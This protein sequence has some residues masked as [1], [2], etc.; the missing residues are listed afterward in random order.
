[1]P[2][3]AQTQ[4]ETTEKLVRRFR[5]LYAGVTI[6]MCLGLLSTLLNGSSLLPTLGP[7]L[8]SASIYVGLR[9]RRD[10][11]VPLAL[12]ISAAVSLSLCLAIVHPAADAPALA[13]KLGAC[14]ALLFFAYQ[15]SVFRRSEV[16][17]HFEYRGHLV[18]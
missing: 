10:W 5:R 12:F 1:M 16:R 13:V 3:K 2:P 4:K 17:K 7:L 8:V 11:V 14:A 9:L 6:V 15:F 18:F